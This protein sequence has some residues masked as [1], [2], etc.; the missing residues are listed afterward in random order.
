MQKNL[1]KDWAIIGSGITEYDIKMREKLKTQDYLT[2]LIELDPQGNQSC[3]I[4]GSM[5]DYVPVEKN[6]HKLITA[7]S[8]PKIKIVS[9][10]VT[11]GGYFLD[12]TGKFNINDP[13]IVHDIK[14][15]DTPQTV[16]GVIVSAL[17]NR[18]KND[19]GPITGLSCD[20]LMQNGNKLKQ[21]IIG[22]AKE[23]DLELLEWINQ[24]CTFPNA[25]VDLSLIHI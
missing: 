14:N 4:V 3:E 21:A 15:P 12:E 24:S 18:K 2:T 6:N 25:M 16:F 7:I 11:E 17:K 9:L 13:S 23:Q 1:A 10:T 8:D 22:I 5:I 19:V 20:N